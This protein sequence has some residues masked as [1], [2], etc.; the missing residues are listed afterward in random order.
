M[1][2]LA[3]SALLS[4]KVTWTMNGL[5][6]PSSLNIG[7]TKLNI[8]KHRE[9]SSAGSTGRILVFVNGNGK[10]GHVVSTALDQMEEVGTI[11]HCQLSL[12]SF[13]GFRC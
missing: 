4:G 6:N 9:S 2:C 3:E 1:F 12:I 7:K 13:H 8:S 11:H 10:D 5:M